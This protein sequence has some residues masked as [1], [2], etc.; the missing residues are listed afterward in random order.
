LRSRLLNLGILAH[1][2][3]GKTTLTE[4]LL[5]AAGAI[6]QIGSV[7]AGTTQT[8][9]LALERQR[10]ITIRSAVA[11]FAVGDVTVNLLDTPGHPDFIAEVERVLSVLD[12]VVLVIS[13]V[14]GVQPQTRVLMRA[15]Q[16]LKLPVLL[17]VNKIDRSGADPERVLRAI[18]QRLTPAVISMGATSALGTRGAG[19]T[20][21]GAADAA[22]LASLTEVLAE[23]DENILA[24]YVQDDAG[25]SYPRLRREL[26]AQTRR[27]L[28]HPVFFGSAITGAGMAPLMAVLTELLPTAAGDLAGPVAGQVF[29]IERGAS[30]EKIAYVRM[31]SG[32]LRTR[33]RVSLGHGRD[34]KVTA[35]SVI[36]RDSASARHPAAQDATVSAGEIA[37]LCG[38]TAIQVGDRISPPSG[39]HSSGRQPAGREAPGGQP[40][41]QFGPPTLES[42]VV[43]ARPGDRGRLRAAL[44]QLAEQDPLINV[45]Q[46]DTLGEMSVSL[47]GEVQSEVIQATLAS[48]FGLDV[49]FRETTVIHVERLAG[50]GASLEVINTG[51]HPFLATLGLRVDPRP[52]G[53]GVVARLDVDIRLVPLYVYK[54]ADAFAEMMTQYA[55]HALREGLHGWPV[56]D[57]LVTV[58]DCG[59]VSPV[60][61]A[62][63]FRKLTPLVL[64]A[65]VR[66]A[67]TVVCEPMIRAALEIPADA[68]GAVLAAAARL[69][70]IVGSPSVRSGLA[71]AEITLP[72]ARAQDLTR[73]LSGLT[74]GEGVIETSFGGYRP[75]RGVPPVRARTMPDPLNR[76]EYLSRLTRR[77]G[78]SAG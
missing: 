12:G 43:P 27:G 75:L 8:D 35:I 70:G 33:D 28:V 5:F 49:T 42:V 78:S 61:G 9:S 7:D 40:E 24:S 15:L 51:T 48:D 73:Q 38:L 46:D 21:W 54:T 45:R 58:T 47:Y 69:G 18:E 14:E 4:R 77:A 44:G 41:H 32:T 29:K 56:D 2:D 23:H 39:S 62:A 13:A 11:S 66:Q 25:V 57:C 60:T 19:F 17:F 26:A 53:S 55:A 1:V 36:G 64:M 31:F 3:A 10:G 76:A 30:S 6:D 63:D 50:S 22:F 65:A 37:S 59:Y 16:R 52:A 20:P 68:I 34:G 71:R 74:S 72:A 67:G